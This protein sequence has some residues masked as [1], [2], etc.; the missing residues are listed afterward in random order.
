MSSFNIF[1][2]NAVIN[3]GIYQAE[4][5]VAKFQNRVHLYAVEGGF[6][7]FFDVDGRG[8]DIF[9]TGFVSFRVVSFPENYEFH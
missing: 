6:P 7:M 2:Y 5:A 4:I 3:K 8:N 1:T 9:P